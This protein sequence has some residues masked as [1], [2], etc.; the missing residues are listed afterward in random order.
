MLS[1]P[2]MAGESKDPEEV[3]SNDAIAGNF[4][5]DVFVRTAM[6]YK[7]FVGELPEPAW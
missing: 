7:D 6:P 2:A 5:E 4:N 1:E 3:C